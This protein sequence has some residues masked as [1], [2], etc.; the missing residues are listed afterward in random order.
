MTGM[1]LD[2]QVLNALWEMENQYRGGCNPWLI[3]RAFSKI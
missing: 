2:E 1:V 3:G